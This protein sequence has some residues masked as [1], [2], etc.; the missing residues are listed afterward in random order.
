MLNMRESSP[1]L[2]FA[3]GRSTYRTNPP[4]SDPVT[5]KKSERDTPSRRVQ[6][7]R[8]P[9]RLSATRANAGAVVTAAATAPILNSAHS[10]EETP[11]DIAL[12]LLGPPPPSLNLDPPKAIFTSDSAGKSVWGH[13][14]TA[15]ASAAPMPTPAAAAEAHEN[16]AATTVANLLNN[17]G[18]EHLCE[19]ASL[20]PYLQS[21]ETFGSLP[22]SVLSASSLNS[23]D[24]GAVVGAA[25]AVRAN[26]ADVRGIRKAEKKRVA[27]KRAPPK[28]PTRA[29]PPRP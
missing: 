12:R 11:E 16:E 14:A 10:R 3:P 19:E 15:V 17:L 18:L 1:P 26:L 23:R 22:H 25:A 27:P 8:L 20:Q 7:L 13:P 28:P 21:L 5:L 24:K 29:P 6:E 9:L 2:Q 4:R